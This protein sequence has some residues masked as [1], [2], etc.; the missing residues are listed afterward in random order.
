[1]FAKGYG[2]LLFCDLLLGSLFKIVKS[3]WF[4]SLIRTC[5]MLK[6]NQAYFKNLEVFLK[7]LTENFY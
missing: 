6:S 2:M 1:M 3:F 7:E 5:T 4:I